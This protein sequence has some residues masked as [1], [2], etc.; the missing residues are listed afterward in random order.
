MNPDPGGLTTCRLMFLPVG[1]TLG[2]CE[3][4]NYIFFKYFVLG[5]LHFLVQYTMRAGSGCENLAGVR[6]P[7]RSVVAADSPG[8]L[9]QASI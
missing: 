1:Q 6:T 2:L 4:L 8:F 9:I 7:G 3:P 5:F